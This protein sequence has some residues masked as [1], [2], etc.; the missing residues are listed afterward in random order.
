MIFQL[1][2][3]R[4]TS[5]R[6][7]ALDGVIT[8][9]V[10]LTGA[11]QLHPWEPRPGPGYPAALVL[12]AGAL[13][14]PWRRRRPASVFALAVAGSTLQLLTAG[15]ED[16]SVDIGLLFAGYAVAA[17]GSGP[18][19]VVL[20]AAGV[21]PLAW[22]ATDWLGDS[23]GGYSVPAAVAVAAL[24]IWIPWLLGANVEARRRALTA[25]TERAA[26]LEAERQL[27]AVRAVLEER[28]RIARELHDIVA[29]HVSVMGV[30]AGAARLAV[31]A[32]PERAETALLGVEDAARQAVGEM[33][34]MLGALKAPA[35]EVPNDGPVVGSA[36]LS[37]QPGLAD[38]PR[39]AGDFT[40]VGLDIEMSLDWR[41]NAGNPVP[42]E[43]LQLSAY[44][45]VEQ[46]LTN[47]LEHA[48]RASTSVAVSVTSTAVEVT[49]TNARAGG[50]KN[51][52]GS[53]R[54][55][56]GHG[57]TG[58]RDR[59]RMFDGTLNAGALPDGGYR[60]HAR[61]PMEGGR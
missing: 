51:L 15:P 3:D 2:R 50:A 47:V 60:V 22:A 56:R 10:F 39:L 38:L 53:D 31:R 17:Y 14:M 41:L 5:L 7:R 4:L 52:T 49:V 21:G 35:A 13:S 59:V 45:I 9:L 46:S 19:R 61:L 6:R 57:T 48:G 55:T 34:R 12:T 44:R 23:A 30:Q 42:D 33:R 20:P 25:L 54:A 32:D 11:A 40:K 27:E 28:G 24:P 1:S 43:A 16:S 37:P 29:H 36:P 8:V 18:A 26:R 58:M